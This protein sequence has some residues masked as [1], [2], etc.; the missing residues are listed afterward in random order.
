MTKKIKISLNP[1]LFENFNGTQEELDDLVLEI[2][3][4]IFDMENNGELVYMDELLESMTDE[5]IEDLLEHING[6]QPPPTLH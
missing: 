5:E 2:E 6:F 3:N 1:E 4:I